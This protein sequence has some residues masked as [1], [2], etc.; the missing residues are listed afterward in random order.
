L[1]AIINDPW[2]IDYSHT[3]NFCAKYFS[4]VSNY[5]HGNGVKCWDHLC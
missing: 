3:Y 2:Q 4:H 1:R 5:K